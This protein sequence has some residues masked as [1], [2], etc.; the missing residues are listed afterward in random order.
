MKLKIYSDFMFPFYLR[1]F[2]GKGEKGKWWS[3][4]EGSS[5]KESGEL[6]RTSAPKFKGWR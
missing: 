3:S 4:A 5:V 1:G 6:I 2:K